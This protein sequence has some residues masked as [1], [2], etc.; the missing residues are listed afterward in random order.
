MINTLIFDF[1]DVFI[2]LDKTAIG[3]HMERLGLNTVTPAM[4]LHNQAYEQGQ[5]S[6]TEFVQ[7]YAKRLPNATEKQLIHAWNSIILDFPEHRLQFIEQ[8]ALTQQ[9]KL[10]LLSNTNAL[11]IEKVIESM[12]VDRYQRF[13]GC[14]DAFY[15]S[16]E[17]G[18][19]K[20]NSDIYQFVLSENNLIAEQCLFIDDT[21]ENTQAAEQL[22]IHVWNNDPA[23]E[24]VTDLFTKKQDLF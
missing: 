17:I 24:D 12:G 11:H 16:H 6:D 14:F 1:G 23:G 4:E 3:K 20:P 10:I 7:F 8:L 13:K 15:L 21:A 2:N 22:G 18:Y 19:R 9:Y 5:I